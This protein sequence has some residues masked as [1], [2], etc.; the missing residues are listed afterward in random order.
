MNVLAAI[1]LTTAAMLGGLALVALPVVAH[2]LN[3]RTRRHILFPSIQLLQATVASQSR[4]FNLRRLLM[5]LLRCAAVVLIV[6]AFARPLWVERA[7]AS[8]DGSAAVVFVVDV[9]A[10]SGQLLGGSTALETLRNTAARTLSNLLAGADEFNLVIAD[11]QPRV[12]FDQMTSNLDA[13]RDELRRALPTHERADLTGAVALAGQLL[14]DQRGP[15]HLVILSDLQQTNWSDAQ[16][17]L[18]AWQ[19]I[20][21]G[22][23]V[24]LVPLTDPVPDNVALSDP[25]V[26]PS[27]PLLNRPTTLTVQLTNHG[28]QARKVAVQMSINDRPAGAQTLQLRAGERREVSFSHRFTREAD[29]PVVFTVPTDAL[30]IDNHAYLN[31]RPIG[32]IPLVIVADDDPEEPGSATYF[33]TRGLAPNPGPGNRYD[34]RQVRSQHLTAEALGGAAAVIIS[35]TARMPE[36]AIDALHGYL[37]RGGGVLAFCGDSAAPQSLG[38]LDEIHDGGVLPWEIGAARTFDARR[39]AMTLAVAARQAPFD[40]FDLRSLMALSRIHFYRIHSTGPTHGEA[41]LMLRFADGTPALAGRAVGAGRLWVAN[42]SVALSTSDLG[43]YGSFVALI[44]TLIDKLRTQDMETPPALAGRPVSFTT[45]APQ[46]GITA[47]MHVQDPRG[48][49][50]ARAD[51]VADPGG[52]TVHMGRPTTTGFYAAVNDD[53]VLGRH[54]VNLDPRESDL[55]RIDGVALA[56]SLNTVG[57]DVDVYQPQSVV[58]AAST[59]GAPLWGWMLAAAAAVFALEL[60]LLSWWDR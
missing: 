15:R 48:R 47:A 18:D 23:R 41:R 37:I 31:V 27:L 7:G 34:I 53:R 21:R 2:L 28:R 12:A 5:L 36:R 17:R 32:R 54:A 56:A 50:V 16:S 49:M 58:S 1:S 24:V 14:T 45:P 39:E 57:V 25:S 40:A 10:S 46:A 22:T 11:A 38:A 44:H 52:M 43:K 3:R 29:H 33:L 6:L 20:P 51:F 42:F 19:S 8:D 4:L 13:V 35:D 59:G 26:H 55:N 9:S 30:E 60:A